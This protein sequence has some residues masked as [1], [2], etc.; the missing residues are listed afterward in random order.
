MR[1]PCGIPPSLSTI[2]SRLEFSCRKRWPDPLVLS[3]IHSYVP[4]NRAT[5]RANIRSVMLAILQVYD[6]ERF[7]IASFM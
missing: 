2:G 1:T 5:G 3:Y 7:L 6:L 4:T